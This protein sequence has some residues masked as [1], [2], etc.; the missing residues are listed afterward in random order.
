MKTVS[1]ASLIVAGS[2]LV[3]SCA[4]TE[5]PS[6]PA[7]NYYS[8]EDVLKMAK[9]GQSSEQ[10]IQ[11]LQEHARGNAFYPLRASELVRLHEEGM[12]LPVLDYMQDTYLRT[13]RNEE[14]FQL[15]SRFSAP[16]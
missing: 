6:V 14:R 1:V 9:E 4:S 15:P 8:V 3:A 7:Y 16:Y 2:L 10:I 5:Y 11:N 12:P 13:I